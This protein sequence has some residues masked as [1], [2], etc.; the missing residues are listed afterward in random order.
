LYKHHPAFI[1]MANTDISKLRSG[2]ATSIA[3]LLYCAIFPRT[4]APVR[5]CGLKQSGGSG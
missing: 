3:G 1:G 2:L 5:G 4:R